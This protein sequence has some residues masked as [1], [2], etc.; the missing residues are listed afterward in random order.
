MRY[1]FERND[2]GT[3]S[4]AGAVY[5]NS[6]SEYAKIGGE[7]EAP[8]KLFVFTQDASLLTD[9]PGDGIVAEWV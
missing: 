4:C 9:D 1:A 2:D 6:G 8:E 3:V 7:E 5:E